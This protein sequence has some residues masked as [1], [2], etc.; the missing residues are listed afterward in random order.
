MKLLT[1]ALCAVLA[2]AC[3]DRNGCL[4]GPACVHAYCVLTGDTIGVLA[5]TNASHHVVSCVWLL[6]DKTVCDS[7]A[8]PQP[9]KPACRIGDS[10]TVFPS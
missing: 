4:T 7:V 2:L 1:V 3:I 6:S 10:L 9:A 5:Q 8:H